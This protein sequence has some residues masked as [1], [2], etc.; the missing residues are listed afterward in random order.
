MKLNKN[1]KKL[2]LFGFIGLT[3]VV[4][5]SILL[6][7]LTGTGGIQ[8]P[9][10]PTYPLFTNLEVQSKPSGAYIT[11]DDKI[12][13]KRTP[14][15][16]EGFQPGKYT[17][18]AEIE[19]FFTTSKEIDLKPGNQIVRL[20]LKPKPIIKQKFEK[21]AGIDQHV[22]ELEEIGK[23]YT[24]FIDP[25]SRLLLVKSDENYY[26][27]YPNKFDYVRSINW[28]SGNQ[29]VIS[30]GRLF[31]DLKTY[32]VDF[33]PWFSNREPDVTELP[34]AGLNHALTYNGNKIIYFGN[35]DFTKSISNIRSFDLNSKTEEVIDIRFVGGK[36]ILWI[37]D[38]LYYVLEEP[39]DDYPRLQDMQDEVVVNTLWKVSKEGFSW[40][41]TLVADGA[42]DNISRSPSG[43]KIAYTDIDSFVI[44][45]TKSQQKTKMPL[46]E[47][48]KFKTVPLLLFR[49]DI[50]LYAYATEGNTVAV[51]YKNLTD[52]TQ[53]S[54]VYT[55][56]ILGEPVKITPEGSSSFS[57]ITD[58][59]RHYF[60]KINL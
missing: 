34:I 7:Y 56:E 49:D 60:F 41:K 52:D 2:I 59:N 22:F 21:R 39:L 26:S 4:L 35:V 28:G 23:T 5:L 31:G 17:V 48:L 44:V 33:T 53:H 45:D 36:E 14:F 8:R 40:D 11:I 13:R 16:Q 10:L 55:N 20:E 37:N 12:N 6:V 58:R 27:L 15:I 19:G 47:E 30:T 1:Q 32:L 24:V 25:F 29:A 50:L 9:S 18:K 46:P 3:I 43:F 54:I 38:S 42:G 57:I 51:E